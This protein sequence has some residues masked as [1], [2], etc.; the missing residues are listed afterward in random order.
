MQGPLRKINDI[1]Y[2]EINANSIRKCSIKTK[3]SFEPSGHDANFWRKILNNSI[4]GSPSDDLCHEIAQM[5]KQMYSEN[6]NDQ[7]SIESLI[8]CRL[9]P[10]D[11]DPG[12]RPI[13][14]GEVLRR[15]VGKAVMVIVKPEILNATGYQQLCIGQEAGCEVAIH[16]VRDLFEQ[17]STHGFIEINASNAFNQINRKVLQNVKIMCPETYIG[18]CY[19][20][21]TSI[22]YWW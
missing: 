10:L 17:D 22:Y 6:I 3:G 13:G 7:G 1:I 5:T 21:R 16:A 18:N 14:V 15:I 2:D 11:K 20:Q 9:I 4:Y 8:S 19:T 12:V